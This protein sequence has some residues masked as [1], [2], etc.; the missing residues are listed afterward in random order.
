MKKHYNAILVLVFL[1]AFATISFADADRN[2]KADLT[3]A[4]EVLSVD[5]DTTGKAKF[6]VN[7]DFTEIKF[8]LEI[9]NAIEI[10]GAAGA[11][12]HCAPAGENGPIVTF[13]AGVVGGGFDGKV[14]IEATLTDANIVDVECGDS[15]AGL[16]DSMEAGMTYVNVH[17]ID[18]PGGEVRGQIH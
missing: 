11:H 15:I 1:I 9:K 16:V 8:K 2:F 13:L 5:T 18:N 7:K 4:D 12:I 10:L 6:K 3:G 17:S 14:K